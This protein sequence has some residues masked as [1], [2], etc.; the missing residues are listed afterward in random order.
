MLRALADPTTS[1][2]TD[3]PEGTVDPTKVSVQFIPAGKL[4]GEAPLRLLKNGEPEPEIDEA[5]A[6]VILA[7]EDLEVLIDLGAGSAESKVWTCDFSH[8][9]VTINGDVSCLVRRIA[10]SA[11]PFVERVQRTTRGRGSSYTYA[12]LTLA[13]EVGA[14]SSARGGATTSRRRTHPGPRSHDPTTKLMTV[15]PPLCAH[16]GPARH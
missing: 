9:Y 13:A 15:W 1:G 14:G 10:D 11:V 7:E 6:S 2:Y 5:R 3:I 8:E 16:S 4:K 12:A